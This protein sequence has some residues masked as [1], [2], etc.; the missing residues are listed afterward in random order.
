MAVE[1]LFFVLLFCSSIVEEQREELSERCSPLRTNTSE[2][3]LDS[4][5]CVVPQ[6]KHA[7]IDRQC[8][9]QLIS[10]SFSHLSSLCV[11]SESLL[12]S[13]LC[14][15]P[16]ATVVFRSSISIYSC[17]V[18]HS[19]NRSVTAL[20][21]V[22]FGFDSSSLVS[23]SLSSMDSQQ[24]AVLEQTLNA[25]HAQ[26]A[27]LT[28]QVQALS[29]ARSLVSPP[30]STPLPPSLP[31]IRSPSSYPGTMGPALDGWDRE[32]QQQFEYYR[33]TTDQNKLAFA[34][35]Y[36]VDVALQFYQSEKNRLQLAGNPIV[37]YPDLLALL[38]SRF[39]PIGAPMIAR[40]QLKQLVQG[41]G[42]SV[43]AYT[44]RF[45]ALIQPITNM[46]VDDRISS[47]V[48][49][50]EPSL[51]MKVLEK[52][53]ATFE[54]A[55]AHAVL[56]EQL[57]HVGGMGIP[58]GNHHTNPMG[59]YRSSS[60]TN[61]SSSPMELS[62]VE[63]SNGY[64]LDEFPTSSSSSSQ[65][66]GNV[67]TND[68]AATLSATLIAFESRLNAMSARFPS[69]RKS[70]SFKSSGGRNHVSGISRED[71]SRRLADDTCLVCGKQ[72]HW[73]NECPEWKSSRSK[74]GKQ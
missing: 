34:T 9:C 29:V 66:R 36:L 5:L 10:C 48:D 40:R 26:I 35:S 39:S 55:V 33:I 20:P 44:N 65:L 12:D 74:Q 71:L 1:T 31:K 13:V 69:S 43:N 49:G 67:V 60:S 72:G 38:R 41:R 28:Q 27:A 17:F 58:R 63:D 45:N 64:G 19:V 14:V 61:S 25:Q 18:R 73:K 15:V 59:N 30:A 53:P 3:L 50:L 51:A 23:L 37:T 4:V 56:C 11:S 62:Q 68:L 7:D 6:G 21:S 57:R 42:Q 54:E 52:N 24:A 46:S 32:M 47:Y 22:S 16:Q 70:S 2:S 8:G